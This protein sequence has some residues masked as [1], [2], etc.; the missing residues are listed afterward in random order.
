MKTENLLKAI[1]AVSILTAMFSCA[2]VIEPE[3]TPVEQSAETGSGKTYTLTVV[4]SKGDTG[5]RALSLEGKTLTASWKEGEEVN[6][7]K[8]DEQIGTLT[9]Q[10]SGTST[11]LKGT[12]TGTLAQGDNLVLKF[13]SPK[14]ATQKGTLD[15]IA[16][17]CDYATAEVAVSSI[18][19]TAGTVTIGDARFVSQQAVVKFTLKWNTGEPLSEGVDQLAIQAG[20]TT[21]ITVTP[22]SRSNILFVAKPIPD[23]GH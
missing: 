3:V 21:I 6:V 13:C 2:K 15:Y 22:D 12:I 9:A 16:A 4:A 19:E 1:A 18:D 11:T 8:G 14:Y 23:A 5:T 17:N 7:Y 10:S 20:E